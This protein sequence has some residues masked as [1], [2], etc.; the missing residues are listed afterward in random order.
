MT[1]RPPGRVGL[2]ALVP[3]APEGSCC[4][5]TAMLL[6]AYVFSAVC[7]GSPAPET[8]ETF[9]QAKLP[10][11]SLPVEC[12]APLRV[13]FCHAPSAN[14]RTGAL[15]SQRVPPTD[16]L[17]LASVSEKAMSS[18]WGG[19]AEPEASAAARRGQAAASS[20]GAIRAAR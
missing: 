12:V 7:S 18:R 16:T 20:Q 1:R 8:H 6:A 9:T 2:E 15:S 17:K 10:R 11:S 19:V 3:L 13:S 4:T 14:I 5:K